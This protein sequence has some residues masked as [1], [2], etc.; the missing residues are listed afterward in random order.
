[1][2]DH[3][4]R[5]YFV[6]ALAAGL[7]AGCTPGANRASSSENSPANSNTTPS[8]S[9]NASPSAKPA[10]PVGETLLTPAQ[11]LL[12][13]K[14][15][16]A[17]GP[18]TEKAHNSEPVAPAMGPGPKLVLALAEIDFGSV[19]QGKSLTHNLVVKNAGNAN[20]KIESVSP[21]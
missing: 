9:Q 2:V 7:M 17:P 8:I 10:Q 4:K 13:P 21:S 5:Y 18:A 20:L 16:P 15:K 19:A 3:F 14:K 6:P 1:M 11:P 12:E